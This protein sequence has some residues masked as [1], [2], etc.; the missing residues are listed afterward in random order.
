MAEHR[1]R[2]VV[3]VEVVYHDP[4]RPWHPTDPEDMV[5]TRIEDARTDG[6]YGDP[7]DVTIVKMES[8]ELSDHTQNPVSP[9]AEMVSDPQPAPDGSLT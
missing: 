8:V 3:E 4:D 5:R 9:V 7:Y 1:A 6:F 2:F